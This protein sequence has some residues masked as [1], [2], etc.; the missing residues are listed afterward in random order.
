MTI[1]I[2]FV[3]TCQAISLCYYLQQCLLNNPNYNIQWVCYDKSF[4]IH[5]SKWSDKC[6]NKILNDEE[7]IQYIKKCDYII[8][9]PIQE[10]KSKYF[11]TH[12]LSQIKK[13][14]C[15]MISLQRIHIDYYNDTKNYHLY[16]LSI[17]ETKRRE[18]L[19]QVDIPVSNIFENNT[20]NLRLLLTPN[21]PTTYVFLQMLVD[22]C[23]RLSVPY[24]TNDQFVYFMKN[25]NHMELP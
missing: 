23:K 10:S 3:G 9:H 18:A 24:V 6:T 11:N 4:L 14:N 12:S 17:Q 7:G 1:N 25:P 15:K 2:G 5:L 22:I 21:H 19:H 16:L 8:Y 13:I 20:L